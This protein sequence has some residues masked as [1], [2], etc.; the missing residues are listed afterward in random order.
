MAKNG[1]KTSI[2][3]NSPAVIGAGGIG[4]FF[5]ALLD[6]MVRGNQL[7]MIMSNVTLY[8]FD[9]V[10]TKNLLYQEYDTEE[11][12]MYK[13]SIIAYRY[14]MNASFVRFD[15]AKG[16]DHSFVFLCADNP[17]VRRDVYTTF[18]KAGKGFIDM[19]SEGDTYCVFTH[20]T[21]ED[22]LM[23]SLGEAPESVE[24]RSCQLAA[25]LTKREVQL[26]NR[27]AGIAGMQMLLNIVRGAG[28]PSYIISTTV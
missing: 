1:N 14:G 6:D 16:G 9:V 11:V 28:R 27:M 3:F 17:G 24:G 18:P 8:D 23:K 21:P 20:E 10:E 7:A 22:V 4:S 15:A 25:D 2:D 12:G 19:R 26:G 5:C 13:A